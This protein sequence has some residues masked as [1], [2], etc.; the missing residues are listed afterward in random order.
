[1][2]KLLL[3][4]TPIAIALED[5]APERH[6]LV[7]T[8]AAIVIRPLAGWMGPPSNWR[9]VRAKAWA[10]C[11]MRPLAT[12]LSDIALAALRAGPA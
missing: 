12:P 6:L 7:F 1:M 3:I 8:V 2:L 11:L 10:V 5:L 4:F 9:T